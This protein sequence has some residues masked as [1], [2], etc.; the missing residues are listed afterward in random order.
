MKRDIIISLCIFTGVVTGVVFAVDTPRVRQSLLTKIQ[1]EVQT[2]TGYPVSIGDLHISLLAPGIEV[3]DVTAFRPGERGPWVTIH[4]AKISIHPQWTP[5]AGLIS[6]R[7]EVDGLKGDISEED[8]TAF[9]NGKSKNQDGAEPPPIDEIWVVNTTFQYQSKEFSI[10]AQNLEFRASPRAWG[11]HDASFNIPSLHYKD[12]KQDISIEAH[13]NTTLI[14]PLLSPDKITIDELSIFLP[15]LNMKPKGTLVLGKEPTIQ[16]KLTGS[17]ILE[18]LQEKLPSLPELEGSIRI[19]GSVQGP[20]NN[21]KF[22][23]SVDGKSVSIDEYYLGNLIAQASF[24]NERLNIEELK[25]HRAD[26]GIIK[27]R[28]NIVFGQTLP[29]DLTLELESVGMGRLIEIFGQPSVW[30]D[31]QIHG[32]LALKGTANPFDLNIV[33]DLN[34]RQFKSLQDNYRNPKAGEALVLPDGKIRGHAHAMADRI[35]L[36]GL[37]VSQGASA[38]TTNGTL[39]YNASKGMELRA[40]SQ[41][42]NLAE[43]SPI[44]GLQYRGRGPLTATIE[45]PYS[46]LVIS[47]TTEFKGFGIDNFHLGQTQATAIF[48][49]N[50]LELPRIFIQRKPGS[51]EGSARLQFGSTPTFD[52]AF[53][54]KQALAAPLLHSVAA[55]PEHADRFQGAMSG[56]V[57]IS[58]ELSKPN[59]RAQVQ[60]DKL[61]IDQVDFGKTQVSIN[62]MPEDPWLTID[63]HHKP[64]NGSLEV[65]MALH[66]SDPTQ[67]GFK[68]D[69]V[70]M[71]LITPFL[72]RLEAQGNVSGQ[73]RFN[74][75]LTELNGRAALQLNEF[76]VYGFRLGQTD[77]RIDA[78]NGQSKVTG[79]CLAGSA[80]VSGN[81]TLGERL[82]YTATMQL[83]QVNIAQIHTLPENVELWLTGS[84]FSQGDF[85]RP[86]EI[87]ADSVFDEARLVWNDIEFNQVRSVRMNYSDEVLEFSDAAFAIPELTIRLAGRMPL[88]S[89]LSLR[90]NL[91]GDL[92]MVPRFWAEVDS[93]QGAINANVL[94]EGTFEK[95]IYAGHA[96]IET[97]SL[98]L[99]N[100]QQEVEDIHAR[101]DISGR[102]V[103]ITE[104]SARVGSGTIRLAG[105][106]IMVQDGPSQTNLQTTFSSVRLRPSEDLDLTASGTLNLLGNVGSLE[107]RGDIELLSLHYTSNIE[108][109]DML[110][111]KAKPLPLP[112]LSPG[113]AWNLRVN[114]RGDNN[115]LF[116][117]NFLESELSANLRLTG[118][119]QHMGAIGTITPIWGR[120][121]YA[122]NTYKVE[123]GIIDFVEEY[124]IS[125][126]FEVRAS[127]QACDMKLLVSITGNDT[128]YSVQAQGQD[129]SGLEID[130]QEALV[131][132]QF[133]L[134]LD[135]ENAANNLTN[136]GNTSSVLSG[137]VDAI[138][139]VTGM[140]ERVRRILP[141]VDQFTLTSGYSKTSHKTEPRILVTK[142]LGKNWELKY[143]GP[144][145][146]KDE[147]HIIAL[148]YRLSSRITLESTWVSVSDAI[149]SLGDLGLDLRL[150]W[151]FE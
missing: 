43:I 135:Q 70:D 72:G 3:H 95:P 20:L 130:S 67:F 116:T 97:G 29:L 98:R 110:R 85:S 119:T 136:P 28:G 21:L 88:N 117:N 47:G 90:L 31:G 49:N 50:A 48:A 35:T 112:G 57:T 69:Q 77:L 82:P 9:K 73:G 125:P 1:E 84:L 11:G 13:G 61:F 81:M 36:D 66:Q 150:D 108:L 101:L 53:E 118:T 129:D 52:G 54:L 45:G 109:D 148:E 122:G 114:I 142:E 111:K 14:G 106:I 34:V 131:C 18:R 123:R 113:E 64:E 126:R 92:S 59:V 26:L 39:Y 56:H 63:S 8:V 103:Q 141:V 87:I 27:T 24:D 133:G 71:E 132:A 147:Q 102:T 10:G 83:N 55:I 46:D 60:T 44:A 5:G 128:G 139:K 23:I 75:E 100:L 37:V 105:G 17:A 40:V 94:M 86:E 137:A 80:N 30:V 7:L 58:G 42:F 25:I 99:T 96:T 104:G 65:Y 143:N 19:D 93:G 144:L 120:A 121:T 76:S 146:E 32:S 149:P 134:R 41:T 145:Y 140:D 33:S 74:G 79:S 68:A 138:W 78:D 151:Q 91:N 12:A 6:T 51:I 62:M 4:R 15:G 2:A 115:L 127:T 107:L 22:S 38:L 89:D 16:M 124:S